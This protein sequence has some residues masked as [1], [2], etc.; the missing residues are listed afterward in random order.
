MWIGFICV[1]M[2]Y[3]IMGKQ[4]K[5]ENGMNIFANGLVIDTEKL[6]VGTPVIV[7]VPDVNGNIREE[8]GVVADVSIDYVRVRSGNNSFKI[9]LAQLVTDK[10]A[11][12]I[13]LVPKQDLIDLQER[14]AEYER[15]G[16]IVN[17]ERSWKV[18]YRNALR[19]ANEAL[20]EA[21][22]EPIRIRNQEEQE[23]VDAVR[24]MSLELKEE[25]ES[26]ENKSVAP[27]CPE[28]G[29][30]GG[31]MQ[32]DFQGDIAWDICRRCD[33]EGTY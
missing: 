30:E 27:A 7:H 18:K 9:H 31:Y 12:I 19:K 32:D 4:P 5:G 25:A 33:G 16:G 8:I 29:G 26:A 1:Y 22:L 10:E 14:L 6:P 24:Q 13:P 20:K 15:Q 21:G 3:D 17:I 23:V 2:A 11:R 28:C